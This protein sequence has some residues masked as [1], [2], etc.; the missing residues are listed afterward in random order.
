MAA[1]AFDFH[2]IL[3][4]RVAAMVAAVT[5][6]GL[7]RTVADLM[8]AFLVVSHSDLSPLNKFCPQDRTNCT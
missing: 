3:V 2:D 6:I 5:G 4:I 8:S 1:V 7:S